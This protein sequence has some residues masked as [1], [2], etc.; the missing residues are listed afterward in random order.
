M[1]LHLQLS[2]DM[3]SFLHHEK[4]LLTPKGMI[5]GDDEISDISL[6]IL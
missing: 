3:N 2:P 1:R 6:Q 5:N 4:C